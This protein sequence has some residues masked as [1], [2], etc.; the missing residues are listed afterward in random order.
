MAGS[1]AGKEGRWVLGQSVGG[2]ISKESDFWTLACSAQAFRGPG[3]VMG[4]AMRKA[5]YKAD[6]VL[7]TADLLPLPLPPCCL[8]QSNCFFGWWSETKTGLTLVYL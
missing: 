5:K 6:S 7:D 8:F 3:C 4:L 2:G 1:V